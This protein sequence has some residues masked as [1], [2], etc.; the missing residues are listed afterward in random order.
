MDSVYEEFLKYTDN[1]KKYGPNIL[2]KIEHTFRVVKLCETIALSLNLDKEDIKLA[3]LGGL[4]HDIGRFE[5]YKNYR[6]YR[7]EISIDHGDLGCE[8]LETELKNIFTTPENDE[9]IKKIVKNHN[10]YE[11]DTTLNE[12]ET[13]LCKIVRD[14][15]KLDIFNLVLNSDILD[16]ENTTI[17]DDVYES[18][19]HKKLVSKECRKTKA[20]NLVCNLAFIF[21][22]NFPKTLEIIK[23]KD[24]LNKLIDKYLVLNNNEDFKKKILNMKE[25]LK[26]L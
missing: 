25:L 4:M 15:D 2:R 17:S 13:L 8:L 6:T 5:Q 20:D 26:T 24:Y 9:I 10:K 14:A 11:I 3:K 22:I 18:F 16:L 21:D 12:K 19:M 23:E 7:D 1:Y